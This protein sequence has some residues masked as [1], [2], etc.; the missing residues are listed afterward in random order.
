MFQIGIINIV[1]SLN[2]GL[3]NFRLRYYKQ[4]KLL[5]ECVSC[6]DTETYLCKSFA[7]G[8]ERLERVTSVKQVGR[9][10]DSDICVRVTTTGISYELSYAGLRDQERT[11]FDLVV[12]GTWKISN[13]RAF[14]QEYGLEHLKTGNSIAVASFESTITER[15]RQGIS[16]KIQTLSYDLIKNQAALPVDWWKNMLPQ[17]IG[18]D[19]LELVEVKEVRYESAT[20]D[21]T[22]EMK[23][24]RELLALEDAEREEERERKLVQQREQA[25]YE[26][27]VQSLKVSQELSNDRL[28]KLSWEHEQQVLQLERESEIAT[29]KH[30]SEKAE[31][32]AKIEDSRNRK[33][34][35]QEILRRAE[36]AEGHTAERLRAIEDAIREQAEAALFAK[37]VVQNGMDITSRMIA[38]VAGV[39]T[40]T[41]SLLGKTSGPAYL[42]QVFREKNATSPGAVIMEKVELRTRDIGT[43]RVDTLAINSPLCFE[44]RANRAGYAT[45][46]NIG[47][48]GRVYLQSPNAYVGIGR[49]QVEAGK[50]YQVPGA[51]LL[52]AEEMRHNGLAYWE[53]GPPGWEELIV[54]ISNE[55]LMTNADLFRSM[56]SKPFVTLSTERIEQ[57]LDQLAELPVDGWGVGMLSFLVE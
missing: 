5:Q 17:W 3:G 10:N 55:P 26:E 14:L 31:L 12:V 9:L 22:A 54:I 57:L 53:V 33:E 7:D 21:R 48:S 25:E 47:T 42:A 44:F 4:K 16:D 37:R 18:F 20:A 56:A 49:G 40:S 28:E 24:R 46:L 35:A 36:E 30:E 6:P 15:C 29:L 52:P 51:E 32:L 8:T 27:A 19:W 11:E 41:L 23:R 50:R 43:K 1:T 38:T 39:S 13:R 34:A 45:V 2:L